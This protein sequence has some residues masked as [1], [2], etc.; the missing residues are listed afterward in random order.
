[1]HYTSDYD[2]S[3][4]NIIKHRSNE[5]KMRKMREIAKINGFNE[6]TDK[7][8]SSELE[9]SKEIEGWNFFLFLNDFTRHSSSVMIAS[10]FHKDQKPNE[11]DKSKELSKII[12][13]FKQFLF[14][15]DI[16]GASK[17]WDNKDISPNSNDIYQDII[18]LLKDNPDS[19][20]LNLSEILKD[21]EY[22]I[23]T[24]IIKLPFEDEYSYF[25]YYPF[26]LINGRFNIKKI[27]PNL[28]K[29][30]KNLKGNHGRYLEVSLFNPTLSKCNELK[31][32]LIASLK[33]IS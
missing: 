12:Q 1:M 15:V 5:I 33:V 17:K 25:S 28:T 18:T 16:F 10:M 13:K 3:I 26:L 14:K 27:Q 22:F 2:L 11:F 24:D 8:F 32:D 9:F 4:K 30:R 7:D 21:M 23:S 20:K 6:I 29:M 19:K 31:K